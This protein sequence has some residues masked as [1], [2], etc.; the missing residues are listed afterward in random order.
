M[1]TFLDTRML[2]KTP[3]LL[4]LLQHSDEK[5]LMLLKHLQSHMQSHMHSHMHMHTQGQP[6][7][8]SIM[9]ANKAYRSY[10]NF[11]MEPSVKSATCW[12][13][14]WKEYST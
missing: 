4:A 12:V 11:C 3:A 8:F 10:F 5:K 13:Y 14:A 7:A 1:S 2:W 9:L 6:I